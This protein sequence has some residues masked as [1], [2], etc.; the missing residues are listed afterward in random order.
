MPRSSWLTAAFI[1]AAGL[2]RPEIAF[3]LADGYYDA[4]WIDSGRTT[5]DGD[6]QNPALTSNVSR[7]LV[8][9]SGNLI[10]FGSGWMGAMQPDGQWVQAFGVP[11]V[12]AG[13][14]RVTS[15]DVFFDVNFVAAAKEPDGNYLVL[16]PTLLSRVLAMASASGASAAVPFTGIDNVKGEVAVGLTSGGVAVQPD[17]KVL[18]AGSGY[19][20]QVDTIAKFGIVRLNRSDLSLDTSFKGTSPPPPDSDVVFSGGAVVAASPSDNGEQVTDI[21]LQPDGRI[22]LVGAGD[23]NL[24]LIRLNTDGTLDPT[25]GNG[26]IAVLTWTNG[27]IEAVRHATLDRAGRIVVALQGKYNGGQPLMVVARVT[28]SGQLDASFG[29]DNGFA[30]VSFLSSCSSIFANA[31]AID[32]AGRILVIG[33]C[34]AP[35]EGLPPVYFIVIR[36]RGDTGYVDGSF[37]INGFGLG[38]YNA[39]DASAFLNNTIVFDASGRPVVGGESDSHKAGVARLTYDLIHTNNFESTPRGC[40][41]PACN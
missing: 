19:L 41:P 26:G 16:G 18:V 14:G 30:R 39:V 22:V 21:L 32:S 10:L 9:A 4:N 24:E 38:L 3:A 17:G 35:A 5:F 40:L 27:A 36:L 6:Y 37:G 28:A 20:S 31:V 25:F 12:P 33:D 34:D 8:D 7:I 13:T 15:E 2:Q 29:A 23:L 1:L 11:L